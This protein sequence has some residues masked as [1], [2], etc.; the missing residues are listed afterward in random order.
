[1]V[2]KQRKPRKGMAYAQGKAGIVHRVPRHVMTRCARA[3]KRHFS[4]GPP[5]PA[6]QRSVQLP[7]CLP[8][9]AE[10]HSQ[11]KAGVTAAHIAYRAPPPYAD[12]QGKAGV[13]RQVPSMH[14]VQP[15]HRPHH[16][17]SQKKARV[18]AANVAYMAPPSVPYS[19][20]KAGVV[21][22]VLGHVLCQ[23]LLLPAGRGWC[24]RGS[25]WGERA[26]RIRR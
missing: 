18:P 9:S 15:T 23:L 10:P 14:Y 1:M 7:L 5:T 12:S 17:Y 19:Q 8:Q 24:R 16:A 3:G 25:G 2:Y 13:V 26:A 21:R 22:R 4:R 6:V 20:W 11:R